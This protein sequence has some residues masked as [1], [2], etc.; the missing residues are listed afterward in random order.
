MFL[1]GWF[2]LS[3]TVQELQPVTDKEKVKLADISLVM[4]ILPLL[5]RRPLR[6][7]VS[8]GSHIATCLWSTLS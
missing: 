1:G 6:A 3:Q 8:F 7:I 5:N 2:A 4:A